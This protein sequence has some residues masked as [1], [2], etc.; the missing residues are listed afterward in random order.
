M[1]ESG[2]TH[3]TKWLQAG[4]LIGNL[5]AAFVIV[6]LISNRSKDAFTQGEQY[7][8][9]LLLFVALGIVELLVLAGDAFRKEQRLQKAWDARAQLDAQ[10]QEVRRMLHEVGEQPHPGETELF[11]EY[12]RKKLGDLEHALRDACSKREIQINET[13]LE[14]TS[15]LLE[16]SYHGRENDIFRAIHFSQDEDNEFFFDDHARRYFRQTYDLVQLKRIKGVRRI[17]LYDN[18][19]DLADPRIVRLIQ[20]HQAHQDYEVRL[21]PIRTFHSFLADYNLQHAAR[22]FGV[23][24]TQYLYKAL[25]NRP[26]EIVGFYS[27]DVEEIK[28]FTDCFDTCWESA[29]DVWYELPQQPDDVS[30]DWLFEMPAEAPA[31]NQVT[32]S[33]Q[34]SGSDP[35]AAR[36]SPGLDD[37]T[38]QGTGGTE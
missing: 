38:P 22:D 34:P 28:R 14:V 10:M 7:I 18:V 31:L 23:Y 4:L 13:M 19:S 16:A 20:F 29:R 21:L 12:F 26:D 11:S 36:S 2:D 35:Q 1:G 5:L 8:F 30:L 37:Q 24:G 25:V 9:G 27:R 6:F 33:A 3:P 15:W 17:I 32:V